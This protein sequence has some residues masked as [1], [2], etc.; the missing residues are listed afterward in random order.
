MRVRSERSPLIG[1]AGVVKV[2]V[3]RRVPSSAVIDNVNKD[4][5]TGRCGILFK[6]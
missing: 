5:D 2:F 3:N 1:R 4:D 6:L